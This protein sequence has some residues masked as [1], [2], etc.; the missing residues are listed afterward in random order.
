MQTSPLNL[1][2]AISKCC[3]CFDYCRRI[4]LVSKHVHPYGSQD[5]KHP[6]CGSSHCRCAL[7]IAGIWVNAQHYQYSDINTF[8]SANKNIEAHS[9]SK[10]MLFLKPVYGSVHS[11]K[12]K[13][14][15]G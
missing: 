13:P 12:S 9:V 14:Q 1:E 10:G 6:Q 11:S 4:A 7:A 2:N 5:Q 8:F 15:T 3:H